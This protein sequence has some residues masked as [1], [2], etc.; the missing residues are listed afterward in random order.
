MYWSGDNDGH[1]SIGQF[2]HGRDL[3]FL[4]IRWLRGRKQECVFTQVP[5]YA[6][7]KCQIIQKRIEDG[8]V[9][10]KN[11]DSPILTENY[12]ELMEN[13][14]SSSGM[15][16][17]DLRHWR[18]SRRP[19]KTCKIEILSLKSLKTE[20][21][22]CQC[23]MTS[24][25]RRE[26]NQKNV[27]QIPNKSR[28]TRR[29]SR[30]DT[31]HSSALETKRNGLELSVIHLKENGTPPPHRWWNASKKPVTQ[32]SRVSVSREIL[33]RKKTETPY[34]SMRMLQTQNSYFERFTQQISSVP[35]EQS[36]AGVKSSV[37]GRM[38]QRWLQKGSWQK[39]MSSYWRIRNRK[40]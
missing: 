23:S 1:R 38:W 36:Q 31:G 4:T 8:K 25:G 26:E 16:S 3:H 32:Y 29:G 12:L 7:G 34:T 40:K 24:N 22:S 15:F 13:R 9:K 30:Q 10:L 35:T 28:I 39:K 19:R 18:S 11:F 20:L 27:I 21:S 6:W 33:K 14:L 37:W 2:L 17:Q 5:S